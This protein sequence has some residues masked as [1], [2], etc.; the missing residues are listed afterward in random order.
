[1]KRALFVT[2]TAALSIAAC[3]QSGPAPAPKHRPPATEPA[4]ANQPA[5]AGAAADSR[6]K[7]PPTKDPLA[8]PLFWSIERDG[9]TSYALG[10]IHVGVDAEA[11]LPKIVWDQI[12]S[13]R[14]FAMETDLTDPVL[15][16]ILACMKCSLRKDLG[17]TYWAKL[18]AVLGED[19]AA[20]IE[21]MKPMVA[22]TMMSLRGLPTTTQMDTLLLTR[23][24]NA[25]KTIVYLE[26]AAKEGAL[27]EKWM[28]V[29]ALKA[30]L[31][32]VKGGEK[33]T[34]EM[35]DAYIAGDEARMVKLSE[36]EKQTALEHG[37]T[38]A[39]YD[40]SMQDMLYVRNAAWIAPIEKLHAAGGGF[41][42]VGAMHLVGPKNVLELLAGKGYK[43]TRVTP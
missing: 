12:D 42:A 5:P 8:R 41:I 39:E 24:Q 34:K 35:L 17:A 38:A 1:M 11:R 29:K 6:T 21:P 25:K 9:K 16:K 22:A 18:E 15:Q 10:T 26:P 13:T 27:L 31:D 23:A 33:H 2:L 43:I 36:D 40:E 32:D 37:Y 30:M 4:V 20:R 14:T 19:L 7:E 3:K 28:T